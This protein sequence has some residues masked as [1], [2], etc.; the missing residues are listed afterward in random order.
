[1]IDLYL[2]YLD[3]GLGWAEAKRSDIDE[4]LSEVSMP[5]CADEQRLMA[6][7]GCWW[8]WRGTIT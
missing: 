3:G 4:Q 5:S 1:V 6:W 2:D 7:I 8:Q